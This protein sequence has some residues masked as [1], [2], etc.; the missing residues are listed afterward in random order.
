MVGSG[1]GNTGGISFLIGLLEGARNEHDHRRVGHTRVAEKPF[2]NLFSYCQLHG[3]SAVMN[4]QYA[5]SPG[6]ASGNFIAIVPPTPVMKMVIPQDADGA[7]LH[8]EVTFEVPAEE[9]AR[10]D[11]RAALLPGYVETLTKL[12]NFEKRVR[13]DG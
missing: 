13:T 7:D 12:I 4:S 3:L 2:F 1:Q 11:E 5:Y 6:F 9:R 10:R 8:E